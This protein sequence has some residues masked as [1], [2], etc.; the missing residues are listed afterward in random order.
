LKGNDNWAICNRQTEK[1]KGKEKNK[2][3]F[4]CVS[5]NEEIITVVR[6]QSEG[7]LRN[8]FYGVD[9]K[10]T[11]IDKVKSLIKLSLSIGL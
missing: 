3:V 1:E 2:K 9:E 8:A 6:N 11:W 4:C 5:S 7:V 10:D